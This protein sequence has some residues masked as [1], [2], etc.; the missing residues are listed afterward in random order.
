MFNSN[1]SIYLMGVWFFTL[2]QRKAGRCL[3]SLHLTENAEVLDCLH[4]TENAGVLDCIYLTENTG[5]LD[6]IH[7]VIQ[8]LN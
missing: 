5:V 6:C 1:L 4:L 2:T 7:L 3:E 8:S